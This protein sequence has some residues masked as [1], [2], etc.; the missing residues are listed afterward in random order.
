MTLTLNDSSLLRSDAFIAGEWSCA[1]SGARFEVCNPADGA[2]I[3]TVPDLTKAE[4][5]R[6]VEAASV[7]FATW[8]EETADHRAEVLQRWYDMIMSAEE[9]LATIL[10]A[11]QGKPLTEARGE[12]AYGASF[13]KWFAE[14]ARRVYGDVI[15]GPSAD[16][17]LVV[18]KQPVGVVGAITPWNFPVAMITRKAAPALAAGCPIIIKPAEETPLSAL[19]LAVL[20]D[21]A[22]V[23]KGV[24]SVVPCS[25]KNAPSIGDEL[26][27]N[28]KVRKLSFTGSTEVGKIL[29]GSSATNVQ[30][31]SLELGGNA[32]F[33]VFKDADLDAAVEGAIQAKF[34]NMGQTCVCANRFLVQE[35]IAQR[36]EHELIK[37]V[38]KLKVGP[39]AEEGSDQGPLI[40]SAAVDKVEALVADALANGA[41]IACGGRRHSLGGTYF[42]PTVLNEVHPEMQIVREEIFG[43]VVAIQSFKTD[44]EAVELANDTQY[45]LAAYFFSRDIS[46][47][48]RIAEAL[49]TGMVGINTGAISTASAPFGG[50]K[51]SGHGREGSK[52]G[53]DE[54]LETKYLAF[55]GVNASF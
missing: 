28:S 13:I 31:I 4:T 47:V 36:F 10:C 11:E 50:I 53:L 16:K 14:E 42:E 5:A 18:L 32:P 8:R 15:P 40:N 21:R 17:R 1:D 54:Y 45:G 22:G 43:P 12:I 20:A 26:T 52:Y 37:R 51:R 44:Q 3:A 41:E 23:P 38:S 46:R 9:D 24:L 2:L 35:D 39:G 7:A 6:A 30:K 27:Q 49:E 48:W 55:G 29:A 33:I 25:R 34:R 19:A